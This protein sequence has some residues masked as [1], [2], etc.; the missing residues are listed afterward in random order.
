MT[1]CLEKSCS[2]GFLCV[3]F[4]NFCQLLCVCV[5]VCLCV[6]VCVCMGVCSFLFGFEGGMYDL[7]IINLWTLSLLTPYCSIS[8]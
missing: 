2:F 1:T 4:V 8:N 7:T 6:C 3:T 5:C